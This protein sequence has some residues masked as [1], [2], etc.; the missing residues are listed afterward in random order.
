MRLTLIGDAGWMG[1]AVSRQLKLYEGIILS[2]AQ[3]TALEKKKQDD[4]TSGEIETMHPGYLG[5]QDTFYVGNLKGVGR[6]YQ[7]TFIDT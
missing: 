4:I 1:E 7:Q 5:A 2:D 3:I 6:I